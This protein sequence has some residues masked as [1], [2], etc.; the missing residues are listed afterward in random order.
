MVVGLM[1]FSTA[2][3]SKLRARD[4][5]NKGVQ[6]YKNTITKRRLDTFSRRWSSIQV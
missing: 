5:L 1:L 6:A 4:Q 3:C 2:G